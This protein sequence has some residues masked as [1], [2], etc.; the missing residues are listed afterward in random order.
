MSLMY[1]LHHLFDSSPYAIE[2]CI[3]LGPARVALIVLL[4]KV[5]LVASIFRWFFTREPKQQPSLPLPGKKISTKNIPTQLPVALFDRQPCMN[6][7]L[8]YLFVL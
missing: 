6:D 7:S 8:A 4:S 3:L 5:G 1:L 2:C